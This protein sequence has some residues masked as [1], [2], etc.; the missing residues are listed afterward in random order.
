MITR[1]SIEGSRDMFLGFA[2]NTQTGHYMTDK[3]WRVMQF[4][5]KFAYA[6]TYEA[7]LHQEHYYHYHSGFLDF[8]ALLGGFI[9]T[10]SRLSL[11]IVA[12]LHSYGSMHFV[13]GDTFYYRDEGHDEKGK[14]YKNSYQW[15]CLK[16]CRLNMHA[17]LPSWALCICCSRPNAA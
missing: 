10:F 7:S 17:F 11:I 2:K 1:S 4:Q 6:I 14:L 16:S 9:F 13:M 8:L 5:E 12:C 3:P 15:N